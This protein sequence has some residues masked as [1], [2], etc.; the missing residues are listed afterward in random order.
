MG[1]PLR[2]LMVTRS[3]ED[4]ELAAKE[5]SRGNVPAVWE[6]VESAEEMSHAFETK[7]WDAIISEYAL[8]QFSG[9]EALRIAREKAPRVPFILFS[10]S[11]GEENVAEMMRAG[12]RDFINKANPARLASA[13]KREHELARRPLSPAENEA[14]LQRRIAAKTAELKRMANEMDLLGDLVPVLQSY[15]SEG[16]VYI[17]IGQY[18]NKLFPSSAGTFFLM[19]AQQRAIDAVSRWG[20][21]LA[22]ESG[23][24]PDECPALRQGK[25]HANLSASS[26]CSP[27]CAMRIDNKDVPAFCIPVKAHN[28]TLGLLQWRF[29]PIDAAS[30]PIARIGDISAWSKRYENLA[31][32]FAEQTGLILYNLR[33]SENLRQQSFR[34]P[35]TRLY[36]RRYMEEFLTREIHRS[37][38][39]NTSLG[40]I[41][42]DIDDFQKFNDFHGRDAGD[43]RLKM[44]AE[45]L[46]ARIRK[47]DVPCR[48]GGEEFT[49]ILPGSTLETARDRAEQIRKETPILSAP[50]ENQRLSPLTVSLGVAAFPYHGKTCEALLHAAFEALTRAKKAGRNRVVVA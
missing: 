36:N 17:L 3:A 22:Q 25:P 27:A 43:K 24:L 34:D 41:V 4:A 31:E 46:E 45:L 5:L 18:V 38:R 29:S 14:A 9:K 13:I 23:F 40:V 8:P 1:T 7:S 50:Q 28:E 20:A 19:D 21:G 47:G 48:H 10:E 32:L 11:V 2:L 26:G 12:A 16:D 33:L 35:L 30:A 49:I 6:R 37:E 42:L 15:R 39:N 44:L